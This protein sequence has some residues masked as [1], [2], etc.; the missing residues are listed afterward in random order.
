MSCADCCE[1]FSSGLKGVP[2]QIEIDTRFP[3]FECED[4]SISEHSPG[5]VEQGEKV[6]FL[7]IHPIHFDHV[8]GVLSPVAF[9][10]LTRNDLSLLR[11]SHAKRV[12]FDHVL[13]RL[14]SGG[15]GTVER[16]V[17][18]CCLVEVAEIRSV[19]DQ[20]N[21][22]F[23]IYDTAIEDL[24]AHA[25]V[26]VR[27]DFLGDKAGRLEARRLALSVF[28]PQLISLIKVMP[29]AEKPGAE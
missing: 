8:T 18:Q 29:D 15:S 22:V 11:H 20:G 6:V 23:G 7:T 16:S 17:E 13:T 21:R 2:L 19:E 28:E 14:V 24:P 27:K 3:S 9:E 26:F 12:E 1:V 5:K 25:S 4:C 10:Q